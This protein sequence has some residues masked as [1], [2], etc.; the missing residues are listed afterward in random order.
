VRNEIREHLL[1][2]L[3]RNN[4]AFRFDS[5]RNHRPGTAADRIP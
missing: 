4:A 2:L 5:A 3:S 1:E